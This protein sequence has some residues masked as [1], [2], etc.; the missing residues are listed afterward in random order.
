[1]AVATIKIDQTWKSRSDRISQRYTTD[2]RE[3][4]CVSCK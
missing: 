1:M 2:W 4:V 3:L